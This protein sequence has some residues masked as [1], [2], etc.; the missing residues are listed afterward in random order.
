MAICLS[1]LETNLFVS[2]GCSILTGLLSFMMDDKPTT[3][4]VTTTVAE[5]QRLAHASLAYNCK[6]QIFRQMFPEYVDKYNQLQM[7]EQSV[8]ERLSH[9]VDVKTTSA[10][11]GNAMKQEGTG[12]E[13]T[14]DGRNR[15]RTK[16]FPF[17][18][19]LLLV[20]VFGIV[21]ALPLLQP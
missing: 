6:S 19:L 21:M 3:G 10:M 8:S 4:S 15:R 17:W 7:A 2:C 9:K 12:I 20:S 13:E 1:T 18:L 14:N 5:K 11:L 16:K